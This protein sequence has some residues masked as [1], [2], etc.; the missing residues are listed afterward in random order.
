M[1][2]EVNIFQFSN[3]KVHFINRADPIVVIYH[4]MNHFNLVS[5]AQCS[6]A[7][8]SRTKRHFTI[9]NLHRVNNNSMRKAENRKYSAKNEVGTIKTACGEEL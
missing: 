1:D 6:K 8:K 4:E 5:K 2:N 7:H 3:I 9:S